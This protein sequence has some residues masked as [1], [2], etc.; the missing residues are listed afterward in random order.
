M[1]TIIINLLA[2]AAL[3]FTT[4]A[5]ACDVYGNDRD[6]YVVYCA[7]GRAT[8]GTVRTLEEARRIDD[9]EDIR[10]DRMLTPTAED[11]ARDNAT[12]ERIRREREKDLVHPPISY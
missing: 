2:F 5:M 10:E 12:N 4:Q 11:I 7:D 9:R 3:V 6:G 1:K 8:N